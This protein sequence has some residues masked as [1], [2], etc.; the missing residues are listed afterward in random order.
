[1]LFVLP[2]RRLAP[3]LLVLSI[4][5]GCGA[6]ATQ[7]PGAPAMAAS[8]TTVAGAPTDQITTADAPAQTMAASE[9]TAE[10]TAA[11]ESAVADARVVKHAMGETK[12]P[13]RAQ[14]VVVLDTGELD[15][16][17][18]L[19]IKPIGAVEAIAGQGFPA[20][21]KGTEGIE[22]VGTIAEPNLEK[23][24]TL[25]PDLIL[26]SKLR[27]EAIYQQ[28]S[29]IAPTV[30]A[31][32]TGVT[33]KQNFD[34]FAEALGRTEQAE[35]VKQAYQRRIADFRQAMGDRLNHTDVSIVRF[36]PGDTRIY[37]KAS[38]IGTVLQDAGLPRPP[39][40]DVDEFAIKNASE[41]VIPK[42][43]GDV[44]FVT[45]YGSDAKTAKQKFLS[46]PLWQ[47]LEVVQA[48]RVYEVSDDLWMLGIGYTAANGIFD[49]LT[50]YLVSEAGTGP[51]A[52][53]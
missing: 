3:G 24:A 13:A 36:T 50:R 43:G 52:S 2:I 19:G 25:K 21:L 31:E 12:V 49:D 28:L 27:H 17:M 4:L 1:M 23:I 39:S 51:P 35:R 45:V 15:T 44:I 53:G 38:F 41:E 11:K 37:Q 7:T 29:Q 30:F 34:L 42:I 16:A 47:Q 10:A 5:A 9:A 14:R 32:R 20:Y 40:Q 22:K 46:H 48:G 18:T 33:W 6:P 8:P 26:S